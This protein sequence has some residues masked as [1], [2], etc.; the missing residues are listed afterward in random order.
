V[1]LRAGLKKV[2]SERYAGHKL[3]PLPA[4]ADDGVADEP[5]FSF[6]DF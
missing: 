5:F 6:F 4:V 1:I 2:N 3:L